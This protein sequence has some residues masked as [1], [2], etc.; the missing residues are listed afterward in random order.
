MAAYKKFAGWYDAFM[1][2]IPYGQWADYVIGKLKKYNVK[3]CIE[4]R[5]ADGIIL[6]L[7]CGTGSMS[8]YLCME[9]Y[10]V[11]GIDIS[12]CRR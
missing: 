3:P 9:G 8:R 2:D 1:S 12:D 10:K 11:V 5:R 6:E 4:Q 7:G